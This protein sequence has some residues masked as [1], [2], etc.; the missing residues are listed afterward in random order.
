MSAFDG[1]FYVVGVLEK[2]TKNLKNVKEDFK[3]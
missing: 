3:I 1:V 2:I